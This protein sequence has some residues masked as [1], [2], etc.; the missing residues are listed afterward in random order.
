MLTFTNCKETQDGRPLAHG[1]TEFER[2]KTSVI[3]AVHFWSFNTGQFCQHVVAVD[4]HSAA[5][6][7]ITVL[8]SH[9]TSLIVLI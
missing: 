4:H 6:L 2:L 1:D 8:S 5:S 7:Q 9:H 3:V